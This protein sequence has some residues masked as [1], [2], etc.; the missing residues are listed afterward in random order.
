M[1]KG[2]RYL[3]N[4]AFGLLCTLVFASCKDTDSYTIHG[5]IKGIENPDIYIVTQTDSTAWIDTIQSKA[6]KF[7]FKSTSE[8]LEPV[9]IYMEKGNVWVTVWAKNGEEI[10]LTGDANYPELVLAKGGET[11]NL[12]SD[13][14]TRN[15]ALIKEKGDLRD[16]ILIN[17]KENNDMGVEMA[18]A[19]FSSQIKNIDQSLKKEVTDFVKLHPSSVAALV[20]IQ[21][22]LLDIENAFDIQPALSLIT[23]EAKENELYAKLQTWSMKD[24]QTEVGKPAPDFDII[25]TKND[26][27]R[28]ETFK[29]KY[30][31]LM[32]TASWSP[33]CESDYPQWLTIRKDFSEKELGM[34]TISLDEN[35][36]DW[37]KLV[38]EKS[39]TW[40]QVIDNAGWSSAMVSLYNVSEIPCNYLIDK[41][42]KIIGSK[43]PTD[44]IQSILTSKLKLKAKN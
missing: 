17:S 42:K 38:K 12:L 11:N 31:L 37:E 2:K 25:S 26:T 24:L 9:V 43:I 23:G 3:L 44:S 41:D 29:D 34:L 7:K 4:L 10:T 5:N 16:K 39:F 15:R 13:F 28:L 32:F 22:F 36:S 8:N 1:A 33:F 27:V 18:S 19:Q 21:D 20:L 35:K 6:G 30:L 40:T 14:K